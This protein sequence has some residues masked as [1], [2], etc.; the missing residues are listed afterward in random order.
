MLLLIGLILFFLILR[1]PRVYRK[2][3]QF[4][5]LKYLSGPKGYP[6]LGVLPVM[7]QHTHDYYDWITTLFQIHGPTFQFPITLFTDAT[8]VTNTSENIKHM[9]ISNFSNY[10][11]P[12]VIQE[13]FEDFLGQGIFTLSHAHTKDQGQLWK[14]QRKLITS[15]FSANQ[16]R[17]YATEV[18]QVQAKGLLS[19]LEQAEASGEILDLQ[20]AFL[21]FTSRCT[22]HIGFGEQ[23]NEQVDHEK[24]QKVYHRVSKLCVMRFI[25][26]WFKWFKYLMPW[27]YEI[28]N[29]LKYINQ[30][31]Y[32]ILDERSQDSLE[33]LNRK[34]DMLSCFLRNQDRNLSPRLLRDIILTIIGTGSDSTTC[35]MTWAVYF[36]NR[37]P[38]VR[39]QILDEIDSVLEKDLPTYDSLKKMT[40]LDCV[41][42]ETL[43]LRPPIPLNMK[44]AAEDDIFPDG[45]H[46]P[47]GAHVIY[48]PYALGRDGNIWPN[49]DEFRPE[50]WMD[51]QTRPLAHEF[52]VFQAGPRV[53]P[54]QAMALMETKLL[55]S[56]M[57]QHYTFENQHLNTATYEMNIALVMKGG[58]PVTIHKRSL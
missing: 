14:L 11:K 7:L 48:A 10:I 4:V 37:Y 29:G 55:I 22:F 33:E 18:F 25:M 13:N 52:P 38:K 46:V 49:A 53:C 23:F 9:L 51:P 43:R 3:Q 44:Y 30:I 19:K 17:R 47:A 5:K 8:I 21:H 15:V 34:N 35:L 56:M 42:F 57:F 20:K 12:A 16:F 24:F 32:G 27:E 40:Y 6:M 28:R 36:I 58:L 41:L 2:Y 31:A 1:G 50:R 45:T 26:P 39:R 54:G